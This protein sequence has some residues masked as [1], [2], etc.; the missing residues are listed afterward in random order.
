[1]L[2]ERYAAGA[3]P[4]LLGLVGGILVLARPEGVV[5]VGLVLMVMVLDQARAGTSFWPLVR[6]VADLVGGLA[7][8][9]MPY[10]LFNQAVSG[11]AFPNTL[12]AKQAEYRELLM[13]PFV[14]RLWRVVRRP[15]IGAQVLL[16]P[17]F[18]W[19]AVR[20]A[21]GQEGR[22]SRFLQ[23]LPA[24]WWASY[25]GIYALRMP[26]DYQY[27]RYLM[28]T[29][30]FFLLYGVAGTRRLLCPQSE[31]LGVRLVSRAV[32][33]AIGCL[34]V[35]FLIIGGRAYAGDVCMI[36]GEMVDVALWLQEHTAPNALIAAHDIGAIG[37]WSERPIL[38]LAG[39]VTP[40]VI[41]F[42][43]DEAALGAFVRAAGAD[44]VVTFP[45]WYPH[46]T[47]SDWLRRV[48]RTEC[49][50]TRERGGENMAV[51]ELVE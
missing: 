8:L 49:T 48:Y 47:A 37:Y 22:G 23:L 3:H 34:L 32:P 38:D 46:I 24:V 12:Y 21:R 13:Q 51:Y 44:Y 11:Q 7:V 25:V 35:A 17:G 43:R 16:L 27:G 45:S 9:V 33:I 31:R 29:I 15:M 28:P 42:I 26:V 1:L 19:Q 2:V 14:V 10:A 6:S 39:L 5:L 50:I 4:I 36:N 41:P 20:A 18:L 30:P 40:E